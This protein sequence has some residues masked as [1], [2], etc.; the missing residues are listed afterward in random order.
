MVVPVLI[1]NCQVSEY[2]KIGPVTSQTTMVRRAI[3]KAAVLPEAIVT[4]EDILSKNDPPFL[5]LFFNV[6]AF[7]FSKYWSSVYYFTTVDMNELSRD[8]T[9]IITR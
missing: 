3:I 6:L 8:V 7:M 5:G 4:D 2:W 9:S 1:T